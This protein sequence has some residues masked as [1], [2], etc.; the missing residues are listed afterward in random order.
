MEIGSVLWLDLGPAIIV[1]LHQPVPCEMACVLVV[2]I[3]SLVVAFAR[4]GDEHA[5]IAV[6]YA[7][8]AA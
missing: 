2:A 5:P 1:P 4:L 8:G 7:V 6:V 3:V